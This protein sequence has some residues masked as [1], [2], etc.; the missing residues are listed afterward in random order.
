MA[1]QFWGGGTSDNWDTGGNWTSAKPV[2]ADTVVA[3]ASTT[4][5]ILTGLNDENAIA[6]TKMWVQEGYNGNIG[7]SGT[8]LYITTALMKFEGSGQLFWKAGDAVSALAII[9]ARP[10]TSGITS[11]TLSGTG[12]TD[13]TAI[14]VQQGKVDIGAGLSTLALLTVNGDSIVALGSGTTVTDMRHNA[15]TMTANS[16]GV[17]TV[18]CGGIFNLDT[19]ITGTTFEVW[20]G[21]VNLM[22]GGTYSNEINIHG[23]VVD[24]T[25]SAQLKTV[26]DIN[27]FGGDLKI[28]DN[29]TLGSA[30][31]VK[32]YR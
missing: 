18:I 20:G 19:V 15:G 7:A 1:D 30:T 3:P 9:K 28:N 4:R 11:V 10:A 27:I 16:V 25:R 8:E 12:T 14:H 22:F 26:N 2:A 6:L 13:F 24:F 17:T 29:V 21:Q 5:S 31:A 23:G 32:D